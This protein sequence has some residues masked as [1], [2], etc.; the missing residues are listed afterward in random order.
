MD[1]FLRSGTQPTIRMRVAD[2]NAFIDAASRLDGIN[3]TQQPDG[4]LEFVSEVP[5]LD[6]RLGE[7]ARDTGAVVL[8]MAPQRAGLEQK[9]LDAT[10]QAVEYKT[11]GR[12]S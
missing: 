8:E 12:R 2:S 9:F 4:S 10:G 11:Q 7:L 1:E 5:D 3:L 6:R